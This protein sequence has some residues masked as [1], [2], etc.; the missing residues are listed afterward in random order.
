M[1]VYI[2]PRQIYNT[3]PKFVPYTLLKHVLQAK[4]QFPLLM[5]LS[6]LSPILCIIT[7]LSINI[8]KEKSHLENQGHSLLKG[9]CRQGEWGV[10]RYTLHKDGFKSYILKQYTCIRWLPY[11][12]NCFFIYQERH[13]RATSVLRNLLSNVFQQ[14]FP[15]L[16]LRKFAFSDEGSR[17]GFF[18]F[19]NGNS[20][21]ELFKRVLEVDINGCFLWLAGLLYTGPK[22]VLYPATAWQA[23]MCWDL[24][25]IWVVKFEFAFFIDFLMAAMGLLLPDGSDETMASLEWVGSGNWTVWNKLIPSLGVVDLFMA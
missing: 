11:S 4:F 17:I 9:L 14:S 3:S 5:D 25:G 7:F 18:N 21:S 15:F 1:L 24:P 13:E 6:L 12:A 16:I 23:S 22:P 10:K 8:S 20:V 19:S 2:C